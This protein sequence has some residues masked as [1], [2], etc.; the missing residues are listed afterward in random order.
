MDVQEIKDAQEQWIELFRE[1]DDRALAY[2]FKLYHKSLFYFSYNLLDDEA[3]A[4]EIV[5]DCFIKLW[6]KHADFQTSQNIKAFLFI[7]CRN[8]CLNF[9]R[10]LKAHTASQERYLSEMESDEDTNDYQI[11]Q[12]ELLQ[13]VSHEMDA[14]PE[15]MRV[16]FKS[17]YL[18]GK[19]TNE[20]ALELNLSVQTVRNQ[21]TKAIEA[22]KNSLLRKG[23][24]LGI[25][26][27]FLLFIE[28][29]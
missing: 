29:K 14:L 1:G 25:Y 5:S 17:L 6:Q 23:I 8:A 28:G 27:A 11:I 2:F 3:A 21:K 12:A 4:Q 9:I 7:S 22:I 26:L 20:V 10:Q 13:L 24:S 16:V 19:S 15:K 18:D